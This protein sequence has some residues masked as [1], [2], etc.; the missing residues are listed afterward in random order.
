MFHVCKDN[1]EKASFLCPNGTVFNQ[2]FFVCDWWYN[3]RCSD[4]PSFYNMNADLY[5]DWDSFTPSQ[6][7]DFPGGH[8]N[9]KGT[10]HRG[11][12]S[13]R[14]STVFEEEAGSRG[15]S[16]K[17]T[18]AVDNSA[19]FDQN[20]HANREQK[21]DEHT[22]SADRTN[23]GQN[24]QQTH[25]QDVPLPDFGGVVEGLQPAI[26]A[27]VD[28]N[29]DQNRDS[30]SSHFGAGNN[31]KNTQ[32]T[33]QDVSPDYFGGVV[34]GLQ[35]AFVDRNVDQSRG[36]GSGGDQQNGNSFIPDA[37]A[38]KQTLSDAGVWHPDQKPIEHEAKGFQSQNQDQQKSFQEQ[39]T[40]M[41]NTFL[42]VAQEQSPLPF[43][44]QERVSG[45]SYETQ[46]TSSSFDGQ[47]AQFDI[48]EEAVPDVGL[49]DTFS[50]Q[51]HS[52]GSFD[53][54]SGKTFNPSQNDNVQG[55]LIPSRNQDPIESGNVH[56]IDQDIQQELISTSF[57]GT[58]PNVF[59]SVNE[60]F[61]QQIRNTDFQSQGS[62]FDNNQQQS[63]FKDSDVSD[64]SFSVNDQNRVSSP[65]IQQ[66]PIPEP[67]ESKRGS[68]SQSGNQQ[69]FQSNDR[70]AVT[71]TTPIA[72]EFSNIFGNAGGVSSGNSEGQQEYPVQTAVD[73]SDGSQGV[74]G[75]SAVIQNE[76]T[77][78]FTSQEHTSFS[79]SY[80]NADVNAD[81]N[82]GLQQEPI[83][84]FN[85]EAPQG[86]YDNLNSGS[87]FVSSPW[88]MSSF[89]PTTFDNQAISQTHNVRG[90]N[91]VQ[92]EHISVPFGENSPN[93]F[94]NNMYD[95][96]QEVNRPGDRNIQH[97]DRQIFQTNQQI[98]SVDD[99]TRPKD[100]NQQE[101]IIFPSD[102]FQNPFPQG[103]L[104]GRDDGAFVVTPDQQ[105][106]SSGHQGNFPSNNQQDRGP[107]NIEQ[108]SPTGNDGNRNGGQS[109]GQ[110]ADQ[111]QGDF[112]P[113]DRNNINQQNS[114]IL[115]DVQQEHVP[116]FFDG[117]RHQVDLP[118]GIS[119]DQGGRVLL[120]Q[121]PAQNDFRQQGGGPFDRANAQNA[122]EAF[123]TRLNN[124]Q[125]T[126]IHTMNRGA[127]Q[128]FK[129]QGQR[130]FSFRPYGQNDPSTV[131]FP[132]SAPF[133]QNQQSH[134]DDHRGPS[135]NQNFFTNQ[136][137]DQLRQMMISGP[138]SERQPGKDQY[139]NNNRDLARG[140]HNDQ[141]V[142]FRN[143]FPRESRQHD[144]PPSV[145][146]NSASGQ[147]PQGVV[148]ISPDDVVSY[149]Q[150]ESPSSMS[151]NGW[152]P[153][154]KS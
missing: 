8:A 10:P 57:F 72:E 146:A 14:P 28:G 114:Q 112:R 17:N 62:L 108:T 34:E 40:V 90:N 120:L 75:P 13:M 101:N 130:H 45:S 6:M 86:G 16:G 1:G 153:V 19:A 2:Q 27:F 133:V 18:I 36:S 66:E 7:L 144:L 26:P 44:S 143:E 65:E 110:G 71:M 106:F 91:Q 30:G 61:N 137:G 63:I 79:D 12:G 54:T 83:N 60:D 22:F 129:G 89:Q 92:Q 64:T 42:G 73:S 132:Q 131:S 20:Q 99:G 98:P 33:H 136:N 82:R 76:D 84:V 78:T 74:N 115:R 53:E 142:N 116:V 47:V 94:D 88:Q 5:W 9:F 111:H 32:Q 23:T 121:P 35:P 59:G 141:S 119:F 139:N 4:T 152:R 67:F 31:F 58:E 127:L 117:N 123:Q 134:S 41:R 43:D 149:N 46:G 97:Q 81:A 51:G 109:F 49:T 138:F 126:D 105:T 150:P 69:Q 125:P 118:P 100:F 113:P 103:N 50:Q 21:P 140:D 38:K 151:H 15:N 104:K 122:H 148:V 3:F 11:G 70:N 29:V 93:L 124:F 145:S 102:N 52:A 37:G 68:D 87:G 154:I 56:Q 147:G 107:I 80:G 96:V 85:R 95:N 128:N 25:H 77:K 39:K 135:N 55:T 48:S 24:T